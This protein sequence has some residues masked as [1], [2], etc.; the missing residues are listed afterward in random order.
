METKSRAGDSRRAHTHKILLK[1]DLEAFITEPTIIVVDYTSMKQKDKERFMSKISKN[2][3]W[4]W[5]GADNGAGYGE[6]HYEG[7]S[8]RAH[9]VSY[10][11]HVGPIPKGLVTDHLCRNRR[12]VNPDHLEV[13]SLVE[14]SLRGE[15]VGAKASR[16]THC[17]HGH[18]LTGK[19]VRYMK[20]PNGRA[21]RKC[22]ACAKRRQAEYRERQE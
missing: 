7:R 10:E 9:R 20:S 3:C 13:V 4:N 6:F 14:N 15:G 16:Q 8:E 1:L 12:C 21:W 5:L 2:V 22:L 19:N 11:L 18:P 17:I